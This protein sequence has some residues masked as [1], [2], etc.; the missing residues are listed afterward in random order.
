[1]YLD[2]WS[3]LAWSKRVADMARRHEAFVRDRISLV[4]L[5]SMP[6]LPAVIDIFAGTTVQVGAQDLFYEDRGPYTGAVSGTDLA[7]IGCRFAEVGHAER[8]LFGDDDRVVQMKVAASLRNGLTPI[9]C[10]GELHDSSMAAAQMWCLQQLESG[11][12]WMVP[13]N[14]VAPVTIAYEPVWAIGKDQPAN[15]EHVVAMCEAIKS[16]LR[17]RPHLSGSAVI[18]GGSAGPGTLSGLS[19]AVDG[20]FLGRFAHDPA[21]LESILDEVLCSA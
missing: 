21:A 2:S 14:V 12:G 10:I 15:S 8:R 16:W 3:T 20:L 18:Y 13:D 4:V 9:L 19:D 11:L 6:S 1:M 17:Q 5:P 7:Q